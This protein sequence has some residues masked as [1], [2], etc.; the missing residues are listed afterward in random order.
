[1][2]GLL[3]FYFER[4]VCVCVCVCVCAVADPRGD[5]RD[6]RPLS[7]Q[8]LLFSGI[9]WQKNWKIISWGTLG[10]WC[11][12][13]NP[14]SATS[15]YIQCVCVR[16]C[17]HSEIYWGPPCFFTFM[18]SLKKKSPQGWPV[19]LV[20]DHGFFAPSLPPH[21]GDTPPARGLTSPLQRVL[22]PPLLTFPK[23]RISGSATITI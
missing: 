22:D 13:G 18:H 12:L 19:L 3:I 23:I 16:V 11:P 10:S 5:T 15:G 1:M 8:I 4:C 2:V 20:V 17:A 21:I 7:V 14:G 6:T 9:F